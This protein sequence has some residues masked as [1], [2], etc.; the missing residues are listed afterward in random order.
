MKTIK[1]ICIT[2]GT[3]GGK[4]TAFNMLKK[5][6]NYPNLQIFW[7]PE[8]ATEMMDRNISPMED[9]VGLD[10]F[11]VLNL[12]NQLFR[13]NLCL[14][15]AR[16]CQ[17]DN[18]L[19]ICDRSS[20]EQQVFLDT[21]E[22]FDIICNKCG[23]T[24]ENLKNSYD[25]VFHLVS[26]AIGAEFAFGMINNEHRIHNIEESRIQELKAQKIWTGHKAFYIF[27]NN[28]P[29]DKKM[30]NVIDSVKHFIEENYTNM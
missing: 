25:A 30:D 19:I 17:K 26:T 10:N 13:E 8:S 24:Q 21:K 16:N 3:C 22:E 12:K 6:L 28:V 20:F 29:F 1:Q 14:E 9:N 23:T 7:I 18:A 5:N 27:E 15:A 11:Q 2:G 4:T